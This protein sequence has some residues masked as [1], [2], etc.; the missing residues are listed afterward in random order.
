MR[1]KNEI[2]ILMLWIFPNILCFLVLL[3]M[4]FVSILFSNSYLLA[5]WKGIFL[6]LSQI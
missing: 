2:F 6:Y 3:W 4:K 1:L 5:H